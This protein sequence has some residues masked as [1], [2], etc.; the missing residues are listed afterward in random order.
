MAVWVLYLIWHDLPIQV[1]EE[2]CQLWEDEELVNYDCYA[3]FRDSNSSKSDTYPLIAEWLKRKGIPDE[4][5]VW[6][7]W[8]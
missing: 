7:R 3:I 8:Q 5:S 4:V 2:V 1:E 6:I